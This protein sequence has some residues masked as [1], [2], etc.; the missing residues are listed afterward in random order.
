MWPLTRP[1][2]RQTELMQKKLIAN[3]FFLFFSFHLIHL[4]HCN[5]G[6]ISFFYA[7]LAAQDTEILT[8]R[9]LSVLLAPYH[10]PGCHFYIFCTPRPSCEFFFSLQACH[11]IQLPAVG[12][13]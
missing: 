5:S 13:H 3:T 2:L 7:R 4:A 12:S 9:C 10:N 6:H 8:I 1:F 11:I